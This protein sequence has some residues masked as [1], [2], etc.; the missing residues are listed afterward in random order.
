M[1]AKLMHWMQ[2][3]QVLPAISDTERQ[4]LEAGDVWID[5]EFFG[6]KPDFDRMLAAS[7]HRLSDEEQAFMDG[8]VAELLNRADA[9]AIARTRELPKPILDFMAEQGFFGLLIPKE[10]GGKGFSTLARSAVMAKVT[11]VSGILS[12]YVVIPNTLGAAELLIDYGTDAQK[13]HYLPRLV[14]GEYLPC[15]GLTEPTA[16]SDAASIRAEAVVFKGDDGEVKLR[17]NFR[18][19]YITLGPVANLISLACT[20]H[21]PDNL[22][23]KGEDA[24]IS[25]VLL[26]TGMSGLKT[27]D[28]HEPIGEA[29]PNGPLEGTDVE[30]PASQIIG[31]VARAGD[32]W[33][34][35]ME[36]L[37]GGR[38]VSLPATAVGGIRGAAAAAGAYSMVRQQFGLQIGRM[39]GV[40]AP[41][42]KLASLAYMTEGA[43]VFGCSAI[44]DGIHPPVVSG[45]MKAYTTE[46]AREAATD[47]MDVLSGAG[48]MQGP[49]NVIGRGYCSAPVAITVEGANIMTRT[50]MVFGQGAT[51]CHPY[52]LNVVK[53]VESSDAASF[54]KNLLGWMGHFFAGI[55]RTWWRGL[56]RGWTVRVNGT[57]KPTR[58]YYRKLGWAAA[59]F[60]LFTD[61]AMFFVGG[62]LKVKGNLTGRYAD[63]LAWM[64]LGFSA[65]RRFEAEGRRAEDLPLVHYSLQLALAKMQAGFEG[66]YANF[67]GPLGAVLRVVGLPLLRLNSL[68]RLPSD[69]LGNQAAVI[70]QKWD[71]QTERL[72]A[73]IHLPDTDAPGHGRLMRAFRL[74]C[75][76]EPLIGKLKAAQKAGT[77][78][79]GEPD[80]LVAEART[81]GVL[82]NEEAERV[83]AARE[84]RLAAIEVDVF[85][86]EEF[87]ANA[88]SAAETSRQAAA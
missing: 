9:Y 13:A 83:T 65:L 52:A 38:M 4:A 40:A 15:F 74:V 3:N 20:I 7:Y 23:G 70:A 45:V 24:G 55:G 5:G 46:L 72:L 21:D 36:Q 22:L 29:F 1:F 85:S 8:P 61:L 69:D 58:R 25:V 43:R 79:A 59:R 48:V 56:T 86:A 12:A 19:R 54:R 31:G 42:G 14:K 71:A 11:P 51:R 30:V 53:A 49:N 88:A 76:A 27:G 63:V 84:A 10:F 18:K 67:P 87:F 81:A 60:G 50:L 35:L 66:I 41:I 82:S 6:G 34:M 28:R 75:D 16:G 33:R 17:L 78:R 64:L 2:I 26:H 62:K 80:S 57:A 47:A 77:L 44:D 68:G 73:D 39:E 37:A 32:G